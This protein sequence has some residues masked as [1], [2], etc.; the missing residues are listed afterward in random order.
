LEEKGKDESGKSDG[1]V[2]GRWSLGLVTASIQL[3]R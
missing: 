2:H 1:A 3:S